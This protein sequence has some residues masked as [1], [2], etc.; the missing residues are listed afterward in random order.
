M[1]EQGSSL[2]SGLEQTKRRKE[3]GKK[4]G[5]DRIVN[6]RERE[7]LY[8]KEGRITERK[9]NFNKEKVRIKGICSKCKL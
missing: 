9:R 5:R 4:K 6:K 7:R 8:N 1:A 2:H 3:K